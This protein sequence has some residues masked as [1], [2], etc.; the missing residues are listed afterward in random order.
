MKTNELP[1]EK[2]M[3]LVKYYDYSAYLDSRSVTSNYNDPEENTEVFEKA[4][5]VVDQELIGYEFI[6]VENCGNYYRAIWH[7]IS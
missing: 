7:K 4:F 2:V 1:T 5:D 3:S 6:E